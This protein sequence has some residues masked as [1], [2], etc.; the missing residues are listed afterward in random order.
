MSKRIDFA[1]ERRRQGRALTTAVRE[2][3]A[4]VKPLA[5][6]QGIDL[7]ARLE[8]ASAR[9]EEEER[10]LSDRPNWNQPSELD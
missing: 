10:C 2:L 9:K 3:E 4:L 8:E 7:Q 6:E 1:G 5:Q